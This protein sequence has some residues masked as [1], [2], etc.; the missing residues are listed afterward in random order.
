MCDRLC[1]V[2]RGIGRQIEIHR[3]RSVE[4][5]VANAA[6]NEVQRPVPHPE[7]GGEL[8]DHRLLT[9]RQPG[10]HAAWQRPGRGDRFDKGGLVL[11]HRASGI[12]YGGKG[13]GHGS[14]ADTLAPRP[15]APPSLARIS[16]ELEVFSG[17]T[18]AGTGQ[19]R[20][21]CRSAGDVSIRVPARGAR[22]DSLGR[23]P[24]PRTDAAYRGLPYVWGGVYLHETFAYTATGGHL[25]LPYEYCRT[26]AMERG[27]PSHGRPLVLLTDAS[28]ANGT[29]N[30]ARSSLADRL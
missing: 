13:L 19:N 6:A 4:E 17:A 1:L 27:S 8:V 30:M 18:I 20:P 7:C 21:G 29:C 24:V 25:G 10:K 9:A 5:N 16:Q 23:P 28:P 14:D 12:G 3:G 2:G 26:C 15:H 22:D 11:G